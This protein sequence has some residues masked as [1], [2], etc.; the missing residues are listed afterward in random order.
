MPSEGQ[1]GLIWPTIGMPGSV[2]D[3]PLGSTSACTGQLST[4][5]CALLQCIALHTV[6][7]GSGVYSAVYTAVYGAVYSAVYNAVYSAVYSAV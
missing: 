4:V 5:Y 7:Q 1:W 3:H 6:V 2:R